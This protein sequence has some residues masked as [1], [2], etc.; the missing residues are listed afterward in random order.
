MNVL[1]LIGENI[2]IDLNGVLKVDVNIVFLFYK[3]IRLVGGFVFVIGVN[4]LCRNIY[5]FFSVGEVWK[6]DRF[7]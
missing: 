2:I 1:L 3:E 4:G 7:Y 5:L 6:F